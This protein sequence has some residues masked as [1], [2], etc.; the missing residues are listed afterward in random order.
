[1][2]QSEVFCN[3]IPI[4]WWR[5]YLKKGCESRNHLK[6]HEA[7]ISNFGYS[8]Q[9]IEHLNH[10]CNENGLHFTVRILTFKTF[11]V[12]S[13]SFIE[14]LAFYLLTINN[15]HKTKKWVEINKWTSNPKN[16]KRGS[17]RV[18]TVLE[19][20]LDQPVQ[21]EMT[22]STMIKQLENHD[23]L[24]LS[25]QEYKTLSFLRKLR[26]KIHVY[27]VSNYL[28]TD[29]HS[30]PIENYKSCKDVLGS[31]LKSKIFQPT[32]DDI[33]MLSWLAKT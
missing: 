9:Y 22:F 19:K 20:K 28:D 26:N 18:K 33:E 2:P 13:M 14:G 10:L 12:T 29:W 11:V 3:P 21:D 1:M 24:G 4:D 8:L 31:I 25:N 15:L 32:E 17:Y 6:H 7:L 23:I 16:M 27:D 30:F 5:N